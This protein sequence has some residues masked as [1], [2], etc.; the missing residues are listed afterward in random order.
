[1]ITFLLRLCSSGFADDTPDR[2]QT[3]EDTLEKPAVAAA[4]ARATS[5]RSGISSVRDVD[6]AVKLAAR[7]QRDRR[8]GGRRGLECRSTGQARQCNQLAAVRVI[9]ATRLLRAHRADT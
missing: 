4:G 1:V 7:L 8:S 6:T 3:A 5:G 9:Q 2:S